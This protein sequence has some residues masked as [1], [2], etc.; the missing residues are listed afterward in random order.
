MRLYRVTRERFLEDYSG[1]GASDQDGARWNLPRQPVLYFA[2]S[3]SVALL[4]MAN[5]LPSP[6]FVPK[7]YRLGAYEISDRIEME[8]WCIDKLP[9]SWDAHPHRAETR[10]MGSR[11]LQEGRTVALMVPSA[12]VP[13]G[14]ECNVLVNP[15]HPEAV[16][17]GIKLVK[18]YDKIYDNRMFRG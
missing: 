10:K 2:A 13:D 14:L 6:R 18:R 1:L 15:L 3:A 12:A 9:P 11:W 17:G 5:Y 4:E 8:R 16:A 7:D